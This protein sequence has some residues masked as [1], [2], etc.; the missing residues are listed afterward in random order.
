[1]TALGRSGTTSVDVIVVGGGVAAMSAALTHAEDG[2][3]VVLVH[4]G[5]RL[6]GGWSLHEGD[7]VLDA[8]CHLIGNRD[9]RTTGALLRL[10]D[11]EAV[12]VQPRVASVTAGVLTDGLESP[13]L[14]AWLRGGR[15]DAMVD[16][17]SA[18]A[19][20]EPA[21]TS[22]APDAATALRER[23]GPLI[24]DHAAR[25]AG[26]LTSRPLDEL[27]STAL[28]ALPVSRLRLLDDD[29]ADLLKGAVPALDD[30]LLRPRPDAPD[31]HRRA[32]ASDWPA[33]NL[34]PASG[35]IGSLGERAAR[36]LARAGVDLR[37]GTVSTDLQAHRVDGWRL[38]LADG[39]DVVAGR[40][41]LGVDEATSAHLLDLDGEAL[42]AAVAH[43]PAALV[44]FELDE[45]QVRTDRH[46]INVFDE[47]FTV[48]R[49]YVP[50]SYGQGLAPCGR[51]IVGV[52]VL[53]SRGGVDDDL[54]ADR[55]WR[56]LDELELIV[57]RPLRVISRRF[58]TSYRHPLLHH[59]DVVEALTRRVAGLPT[60]VRQDDWAFTREATAAS[61]LRECATFEG[62]PA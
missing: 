57:G 24:G 32:I 7:L 52:E 60:L 12:P 22:V 35:G 59:P 2:A 51:A 19:A 4:G 1:M 9:D 18:A 30:R 55:A 53:G 15:A 38:V 5:E 20:A 31:A 56:E 43:V 54:L 8:G 16:L 14:R 33:R 21:P 50:T 11:G 17:L 13:D 25:L 62:V 26:R 61:I 27:A 44:W 3:S 41:V 10:L 47:S 39:S 28:R 36:V 48:F 58:P 23:F 45:E 37:L 42:R 29:A 34:Y 46:W 40:I 49:A 6:S